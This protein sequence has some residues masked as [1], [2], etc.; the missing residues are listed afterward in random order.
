MHHRTAVALA[1]A[2]GATGV[3]LGALG[4][5]PPP[6]MLDVPR[7]R[8]VWET[9]AHY[10]LIHAVVIMA[11][12][13]WMRAGAGPSGPLAAWAVRLWTLGIFL[14]SG[15]LYLLALGG[16][17]GLGPA[18]PLGGLCLIAGWLTA[19]AAALRG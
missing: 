5:H 3:I 15:S 11:F 10:Q 7:M 12:G 8:E 17:H 13:A 9:G 1:G 18:T 19:A 6:G 16:P 14:F 2:L 4:A